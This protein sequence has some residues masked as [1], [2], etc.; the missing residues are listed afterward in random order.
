[1]NLPLFC[2]MW[3]SWSHLNFP[4]PCLSEGRCIVISTNWA[5]QWV[6][7]LIYMST[8]LLKR[9]NSAQNETSGQTC[10]AHSRCHWCPTSSFKPRERNENGLLH[11]MRLSKRRGRSSKKFA[12]IT[13]SVCA[14]L[15]V[16]TSLPTYAGNTAVFATFFCPKVF[17]LLTV[18]FAVRRLRCHCL[19]SMLNFSW[20]FQGNRAWSTW[21]R[22]L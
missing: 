16:W 6:S 17:T 14:S 2:L 13:G 7:F 20:F 1:M 5:Q 12:R 4:P 11:D 19:T 22:N 18:Y 15:L 10:W 21:K 9:V 3:P 8:P